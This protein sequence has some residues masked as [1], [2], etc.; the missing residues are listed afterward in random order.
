MQ[1]RR[2]KICRGSRSNSRSPH[3]NAE[4]EKRRPRPG[5]SGML[6]EMLPRLY[7][8]PS[9]PGWRALQRKLSAMRCPRQRPSST[10]RCPW[11]RFLDR[12]MIPSPTRRRHVCLLQ[13]LHAHDDKRMYHKVAR[14]LVAAGYEVSSVVPDTGDVPEQRDGVRFVRIP[15]AQGLWQR[16]LVLPRHPRR[17]ADA[18]STSSSLRRSPSPGWPPSSPRSAAEQRWSSI[19]TSTC[20]PS[21]PSSSRCRRPVR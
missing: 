18:C 11:S 6:L 1:A 21:S 4:P 17:R 5:T 9:L 7:P 12:G 8:F 19:C 3:L 20:R 10:R 14:S 2:E 13:T 16:A 15:R